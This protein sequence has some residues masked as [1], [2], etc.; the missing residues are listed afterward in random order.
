MTEVKKATIAD[1]NKVVP[2]FNDYRKFYR[3][4]I[5]SEVQAFLNER[6]SNNESVILIAIDQNQVVGFVQMYFTF[7]SIN[8]CKVA[9]L[10]D[11][12]VLPEMR[13]KKVAS[14]L[15]DST[16]DEAKKLGCKT[17]NLSTQIANT[18]AQDLYKKKGF[19]KDN[20]F[21]YFN[22]GF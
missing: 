7:S 17:V 18:N 19:K 4:E 8:L 9:I 16:L 3:K 22:F 21:F 12:Y 11:L 6:I 13:R 15:I 1:I 14:L 10:N 5:S 20:D 2:L